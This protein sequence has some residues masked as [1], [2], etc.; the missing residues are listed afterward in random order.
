MFEH[1][2]ADVV[3][4]KHSKL[5]YECTRCK[6]F[7]SEMPSLCGVCKTPLISSMQI[8]RSKQEKIEKLITRGFPDSADIQPAEEQSPKSKNMMDIEHTSKRVSNSAVFTETCS[9]C[10][11]EITKATSTDA[12]YAECKD[13]GSF[14]CRYRHIYLATATCS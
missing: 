5:A 6:A 2:P 4:L 3:L 11:N 14:F 1:Q 8:A 10:D 9:G 13:C 7:C 12:Y